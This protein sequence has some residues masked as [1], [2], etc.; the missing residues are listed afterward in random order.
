MQLVEAA[1]ANGP[2]GSSCGSSSAAEALHLG[3]LRCF[4]GGQQATPN[5]AVL[6]KTGRSL[7][8]RWL[9]HAGRLWNCRGSLLQRVLAASL[10]PAAGP[11]STCHWAAQLAAALAAMG[12]PVDLQRPR[13]GATPGRH[14]QEASAA[15]ACP[16]TCKLAHYLAIAWGGVS[17]HRQRSTPPP[18]QRAWGR[19]D[20]AC[21]TQLW[22]S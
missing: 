5:G 16:G 4:L 2:R 21:G 19:C 15:A 1:A 7:W 18:R 14:L 9:V 22:L 13:P 17:C 3:H 12:M 20:S 10:Q 8:V 6:L 11:R